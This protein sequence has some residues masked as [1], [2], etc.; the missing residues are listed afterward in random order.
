MR[1]APSSETALL[2][3]SGL[4]AA[5][6]SA[7]VLFGVDLSLAPQGAIGLLGRNGMGKTTTIRAILG[8]HPPMAGEIR[9]DGQP[10]TEEPAHRIARRGLGLVPEGRRIFAGLSTLENLVAM[11]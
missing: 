10:L 1:D 9:W 4:C 6:G 8:L 3:V 11:A 2:S 7:Q 5:Y